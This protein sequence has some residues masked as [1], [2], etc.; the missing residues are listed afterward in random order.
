MVKNFLLYIFQYFQ[1]VILHKPTLGRLLV[2]KIVLSFRRKKTTNP[3]LMKNILMNSIG[4][5]K[6][7]KNPFFGKDIATS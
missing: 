4:Y 2:Q 6:S 5:I 1:N 3:F 7:H